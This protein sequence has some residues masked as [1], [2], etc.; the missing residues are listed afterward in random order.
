MRQGKFT[1]AVMHVDGLREKKYAFY[2]NLL[3]MYHRS[4]KG[5]N[6]CNFL[7]HK[8]NTHYSVNTVAHY[9]FTPKCPHCVHTY[10]RIY[11]RSYGFRHTCAAGVTVV[12][13]CLCVCV[14]LRIC[15]KT[16]IQKLWCDIAS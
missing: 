9:M 3:H 8:V 12:V 11:V 14:N 4:V 10:V 1:S 7:N 13:L 2:C 16:S 6:Q 15:L 5:I